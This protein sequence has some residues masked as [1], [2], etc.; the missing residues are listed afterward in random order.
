MTREIS[1][2][3]RKLLF[4]AIPMQR[5]GR[6]EDVAS[7]ALYLASEGAGYITG[8]VLQVNGGLYM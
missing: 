5:I 7:A 2:D 6:P 8:Q 1:E 4:G 3:A